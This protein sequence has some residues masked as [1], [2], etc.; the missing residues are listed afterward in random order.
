MK[1]WTSMCAVPQWSSVR[2]Q[3]ESLMCSTSYSP[4]V[5]CC[6]KQQRQHLRSKQLQVYVSDNQKIV[7]QH[8]MILILLSNRRH[9]GKPLKFPQAHIWENSVYG[10]TQVQ[11]IGWPLEIELLPWSILGS[12]FPRKGLQTPFISPQEKKKSNYSNC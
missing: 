2:L 3:E 10:C 1:L 4:K 8:K 9:V 11:N 6:Q 7:F 12:Y 5:K